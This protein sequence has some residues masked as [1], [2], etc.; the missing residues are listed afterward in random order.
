MD[1]S[2]ACISIT[3]CPNRLKDEGRAN[4]GYTSVWSPATC[5]CCP[6]QAEEQEMSSL[7]DGGDQITAHPS[8]LTFLIQ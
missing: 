7:G 4:P 8:L 2:I 1:A 5:G 3:V 6:L